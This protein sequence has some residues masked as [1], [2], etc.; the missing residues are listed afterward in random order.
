M[1]KLL[2]ILAAATLA[3]PT[4]Q[5]AI[6]FQTQNYSG[7]AGS[8]QASGTSLLWN[9][10]DTGLG[11]LTGVTMS[12]TGALTGS[13][14]VTTGA[15]AVDVYGSSGTFRMNF[16]LGAGAP[17][18]I[19]GTSVTPL[20][21][22]PGTGASPG[23]AVGASTTQ[24]FTINGPISLANSGPVD[25]F[26]NASYFSSAVPATFNTILFRNVTATVDGE[27][28]SLT[29]GN[30]VM[31]G[32]INLTYTYDA[33]AAIPEPGTWAAAALLAGGAAFARWRKRKVA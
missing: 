11:T 4:A 13:F 5:A 28:F 2:T 8:S 6:V 9:K 22:T 16:S 25:F 21:T 26:G 19:T 29:T 23:T 32:T 12:Y 24:V 20:N 27:N 33:G 17:S 30:A 7:V 3:I 18:N 1:K 10:F 31:D 15:T 14:S